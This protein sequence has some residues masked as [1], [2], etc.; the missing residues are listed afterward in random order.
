MI[1]QCA[2]IFAFLALGELIVWLTG[3]PIPSSIIGMLALTF[4]LKMGWVKPQW[5][6]K[7]SDFLVSNIGF[8]FVP[9]GVGLMN[10]LGIIKDQWLP[11][12][13][14]TVISIFLVIAVTGW[15]HQITRKII[16]RRRGISH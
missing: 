8:F 10:C 12:V 4:A 7:L 14:A 3:V 16:T 5:I 13:A 15:V 9:A 1:Y 2:I 11:I 6:E